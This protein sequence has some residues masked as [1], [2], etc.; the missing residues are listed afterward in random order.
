MK[1][2]VLVHGA[3]S[4]A[5]VWSEVS[6]RLEA[7]GNRVFAP[8]LPSHGADAS[9]P[10]KATLDGYADTV[11]AIAKAAD[12]PV[13][14][15]GHSMAGTVI[16]AVAE[17]NPELVSHLVYLAAYL[18]PNE[19][20]LYG[21]TQTSPGMADSAL[22]PA[23]RPGE[24]TLGVDPAAFID[25]FCADAAPD[26]AEA[27]V[28]ALRPDPLAPLGTPITITDG[29]WGRIPRSYIFTAKDRC[30]SPASQKEMVDAVTVDKVA[31]IDAAHLA[32]LSKPDELVTII[33]SLVN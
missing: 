13:V 24:G 15:V 6:K 18:L 1:T 2:F 4:N 3:W 21:F 28:A 30:V 20:S 11:I 25:V 5:E 31:T 7:S 29:R 26:A 8:D 14:L 19:Q 33:S 9:P 16:S 17:R 23:L 10:E 12:Q 32:M 22:G 27:A